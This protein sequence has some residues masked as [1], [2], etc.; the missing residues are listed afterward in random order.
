[1]AFADFQAAQDKAAAAAKA[2]AAPPAAPALAAPT[3][4]APA[5]QQAADPDASD[6]N[7][8][9]DLG[10]VHLGF[11]NRG[12]PGMSWQSGGL[13]GWFPG[14]QAAHDA[15]NRFA[16]DALG[17]LGDNITSAVGGGDL[18]TL[19]AQRQQADARLTP[20]EKAGTDIAAQFYPTNQFLNRIPVAG[21]TV[22]GATQ[23]AAKSYGAGNDKST[24]ISDAVKGGVAGLGTQVGANILTSPAVLSKTLGLGFP[25]LLGTFGL[26]EHG[27]LGGYLANKALEPSA[28]AISKSGGSPIWGGARSALQSLLMGGLSSSKQQGGNAPP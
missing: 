13:G 22:Q 3:A 20:L 25:G 2:A 16:N 8:G 26:G 12:T 11:T 1:M 14:S 4:P 9:F 24:I 15:T 28:E 17:G 18:A 6:P 19:R 21:P 5:A 23:E 10:P 7:R 27:F